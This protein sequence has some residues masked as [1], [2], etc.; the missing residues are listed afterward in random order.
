MSNWDRFYNVTNV[1]MP[2]RYCYSGVVC[3]GEDCSSCGWNPAIIK[4][5]KARIREEMKQR[6]QEK[7]ERVHAYHV[8]RQMVICP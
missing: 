8:Y 1:D 7:K 6:P 3:K 2:C 4:S 5:R